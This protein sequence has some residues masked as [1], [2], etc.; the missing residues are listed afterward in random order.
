[1]LRAVYVIFRSV[2]GVISE[3]RDYA[4]SVGFVSVSPT[5][6]RIELDVVLLSCHCDFASQSFEHIGLFCR[7]LC[8]IE[9][10]LRLSPNI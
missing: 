5:G 7:G 3:N 6:L 2:L 4:F 9:S 10:R 8:W 1:M